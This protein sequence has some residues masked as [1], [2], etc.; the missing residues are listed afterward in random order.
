MS[1]LYCEFK[2]HKTR[3]LEGFIKAVFSYFIFPLKLPVTLSQ[4]SLMEAPGYTKN[5][6]C[7][8][9]FSALERCKTLTD[10]FLTQE[11]AAILLNTHAVLLLIPLSW[12]SLTPTRSG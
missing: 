11:D 1:P 6:L 10:L 4:A 7:Y 8:E 9:R 3:Q 5:L 12:L 2:V